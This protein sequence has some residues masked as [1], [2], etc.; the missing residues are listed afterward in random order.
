[1][2]EIAEGSRLGIPI[3]FSSD[4]RHSS[5]RFPDGGSTPSG[6][7]NI[8]QWPE[9][10]GFAAIGDPNAVREFGRIAA[11]EYRA[12]GL[13]TSLSPMADV[14]TEPRWNRV[15]GTFGEDAK[16]AGILVKAYVQGFQGKQLGLESVLC[17]TRH[18]P[19]AG[20]V[21]D[22]PDSRNDSGK[23]QVYPGKNFD[24][25]LIPFQAAL[26]AGTGGIMPGYA[27]PVGID[28]VGMTFSKI[29]VTDLLRRKYGF[30]GLVVSDWRR[31][32]WGVEHLTEKDRQRLIVEAGVDQI[33]GNNNPRY[34]IEM[35]KD[36]T[37]P[38]GRIDES[39]KRILKPLF[40]LGLFENPY[41]DP[42]RARSVVAGSQFMQAGEK[43]QR[44]SIVLL[45][46]ANR[47]L[48]LPGNTK[49]YVENMSKDAAARYGA[50]VDDPKNAD[51]AIIKV[52]APY[53]LRPGGAGSARG[54]HEGTLAYAG[55]ENAKELEAIR[56]IASSGT[57]TIVVMYLDRP[58]VLSEFIDDVRA[59]LAHFNSTDNTILD[60]V[61]GRHRPGG[62]LPFNLPRDTTSV[63]KQY[64]DVPHDLE[65]PLF[66]FGFGLSYGTETRRPGSNYENR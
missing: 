29:I 9:Q 18:F 32:P 5:R 35:V 65:R 36:G 43:A 19:G 56:R 27:I 6:K 45:K 8:S 22:D 4:P 50:V 44:K 66:R 41:V 14:A 59:V 49:L 10:I 40:Q 11:Q 57:P 52:T 42:D 37:V 34:I 1:M 62:K 47:L 33:G 64:P 23:W 54:A 28:T 21:K 12:L 13:Q 26:E 38:E 63:T 60:I 53:A 15:P 25:H 30:N 46:N 20:A 61:F 39:A 3:S 24:Y 2:Q 55:A 7:P 31:G 58:A 51:A 17:I 48:P 16:L